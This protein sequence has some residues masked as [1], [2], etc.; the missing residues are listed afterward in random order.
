MKTFTLLFL[1]I[2]F[3]GFSQGNG[4]VKSLYQRANNSLLQAKKAD[5]V[6][7]LIKPGGALRKSADKSTSEIKYLNDSIYAYLM[8]SPTDSMLM[9]REYMFYSVAGYDTMVLY[10]SFDSVLNKWNGMKF[11]D[12]YNSYGNDTLGYFYEWDVINNKWMPT[13]KAE[14]RYDSFQ[15]NTL[16]V[17]YGWNKDSLGWI[18]HDKYEYVFDADGNK[19]K[20][21]SFQWENDSGT[22]QGY[23]VDEY[24]YDLNKYD[25]LNLRYQNHFG[26]NKVTLSIKENFYHNQEGID[27]L[28]IVYLWDNGLNGWSKFSKTKTEFEGKTNKSRT[29]FIWN[30]SSNAWDYTNRVNTRYNIDGDVV[31][32]G[33]FKWNKSNG[34]WDSTSVIIYNFDTTGKQISFFNESWNT[35]L[36]RWDILHVKYF[37]SLQGST[38]NVSGIIRRLLHFYPNPVHDKINCDWIEVSPTQGCIYNNSGQLVKIL[39]IKTGNNTFNVSDLASGIYYIHIPSVNGYCVQKIVRY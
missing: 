34:I 21:S 4:K 36:N 20:L 38:N 12:A 19:T 5:Q 26:D 3:I 35:V 8:K 2:P 13:L 7:E 17:Y 1:L 16:T 32:E 11:S 29:D 31:L 30:N 18:P 14:Y 9:N 10:F 33:D 6:H 23:A 24:Y 15:N 37:Y 22:W 27:T 39:F 28:S 25:S